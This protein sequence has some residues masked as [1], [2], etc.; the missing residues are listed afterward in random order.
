MAFIVGGE[1]RKN[2]LYES[3]IFPRAGHLGFGVL[4]CNSLK[5]TS[6]SQ[7]HN[8]NNLLLDQAY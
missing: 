7:S 6:N 2:I 4:Q 8:K 5:V 1:C 3:G